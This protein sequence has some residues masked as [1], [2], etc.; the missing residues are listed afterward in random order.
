VP[1]HRHLAAFEPTIIGLDIGGTK[2]AIV[3]GEPATGASL[4]REELPTHAQVPFSERVPAIAAVIDRLREGAERAGRRVRAISVSVGGPLRISEGELLDPP[5]LPGWHGAPLRATL[6]ARYPGLPV[7]VEHDGN[8]GALAEFRFGVGAARPGLRHLVFLTAGT[9]LGGGIIAN[10]A[11]LRGAS[12][13][14]GEFGF[15]PMTTPAG[16]GDRTAGSWDY[17]ASGSGL[18]RQAQAMFPDRWGR[19]A[20][21]RDVVSAALDDD[22]Q[23][24]AAV[25]RTGEWFGRGLTLIITALNPEVIAVGTLGVVLGDRLLAPARAM[26]AAT[27]LPAAARACAIVPAA[28][29]DR[30]GDV[31]AIMAALAAAS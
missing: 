5:H 12:D 22:D 15:F 20:T 25:T 30:I 24:L 29:G 2:T 8:A 14:A 6:A 27:A 17:L 4:Q 31:A 13:T 18:L 7:H 11:L 26:V 23:A 28:L 16:G 9:G 19:A 1:A 3:E 10:G 21:I